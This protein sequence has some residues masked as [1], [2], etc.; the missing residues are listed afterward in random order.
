M[1]IQKTKARLVRLRQRGFSL[2][3]VGMT[4]IAIAISTATLSLL[5]SDNANT[6]KAKAI[7]EKMKL[8]TSA[9]HQY[10]TQNQ[11]ALVAATVAG[12]AP[13]A[14]PAGKTCG[15]CAI[16]N[17]PAGLPSIQGDGLL[18][19]AY[20]DLNNAQQSHALLVKQLASG[21]L[22]GIVTTYGG[23]PLED[24]DIGYVSGLLG[25]FGGGVYTNA[26]IAPTNEISGSAGGWGDP[27][28]NWNASIGVTPV[29]PI[30]GTVQASLS[31]AADSGMKPIDPEDVLYRKDIGYPVRNTMETDLNMGGNDIDDAQ[32]VYSFYYEDRSNGYG[33]D[34]NGD[35]RFTRVNVDQTATVGGNL[36]VGGRGDFSGNMT[37]PRLDT[38]G[39]VVAGLDMRSGR[40]ATVGRN[41]AVAGT[42]RITGRTDID[43][44]LVAQDRLYG[45]DDVILNNLGGATTVRGVATFQDTLTVTGRTYLNAR[46]D[47]TG[48]LVAA[49][50]LYGQDDVILNNLGGVTTVRGAA[51]FQS[52][53]TVAGNVTAQAYYYSSDEKLKDDIREVDGWAVI[54]KLKPKEYKFKKDGRKSMGLIAQD[55][56]K[57]FPELVRTDPETGLK[58]VNYIDLIAPM[59]DEIQMLRG[60]VDALKAAQV[61]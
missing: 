17:G 39:H 48:Y 55:V 21:D 53:V 10:M 42:G 52:N 59:I 61:Q 46:A 31:M 15:A 2:V 51:T 9:S 40:D 30:S 18:P 56:E 12:G 38:T 33:L 44:W 11:N 29:Q 60:E 41:L 35:S 47:V 37:T 32:S 28:G 13:I 7:A 20:V 57:E 58:S 16:P 54:S 5:L 4:L 43:G 25:S 14:I 23:T 26:A 49:S 1:R 22:E 6:L 24:K 19:S 36:T 50:R 3:E 45:Q 34:L 27:T 8:V